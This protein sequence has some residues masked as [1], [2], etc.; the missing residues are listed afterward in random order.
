MAGTRS[1]GLAV[2]IAFGIGVAAIA[3]TAF[4]FVQEAPS[5]IHVKVTDVR[6]SLDDGSGSA[7]AAADQS[8]F[9]KLARAVRSEVV[10][11]SVIEVDSTL[12]VSAT[13]EN[14]SWTITVGGVDVGGG[15]TPPDLEQVVAADGKSSFVAQTRFP[16]SKAASVLMHGRGP[17]VEVG[18]YAQVR[19]L[20]VSV[21]H[22][23]EADVTQVVKGGTLE[24]VLSR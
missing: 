23:F 15:S 12:P 7:G 1:W 16:V 11:D 21:E 8:A 5:R 22:V 2:I 9:G 14:V 24:Q 6:F 19:V 17:T 3:G 13:L 4:Y 10:V 18:G 20:G